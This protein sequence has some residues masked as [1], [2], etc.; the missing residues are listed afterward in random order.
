M[1]DV[2]IPNFSRY[3]FSR[4]PLVSLLCGSLFIFVRKYGKRRPCR[5]QR[6]PLL[7]IYENILKDNF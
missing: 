5:S 7:F 6:F 2:D 3:T 1:G 4:R